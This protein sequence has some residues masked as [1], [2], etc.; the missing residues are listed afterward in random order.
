MK[1]G[2]SREMNAIEIFKFIGICR[3]LNV[4]IRSVFVDACR[5]SIKYN[6]VTDFFF[7]FLVIYSEPGGLVKI[8]VDQ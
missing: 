7:G 3:M 6:D 8:N 2:N 1:N 5:L 4:G